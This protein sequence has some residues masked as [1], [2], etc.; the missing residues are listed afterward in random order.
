VAQTQKSGNTQSGTTQS[1]DVP[2]DDDLLERPLTARSVMASLL[3]GMDRPR[4]RGA[5]LVRW[6]RLFG[7]SEG[8]ARV[9]LSRMVA[10]DE[11]VTGDGSYELAGRL[12]LR[13]REQE[14][15]LAPR[16][17]AWD[18]AWSMATVDPVARPPAD[19]QVLRDAMRHLRC[20]EVREGVWT[21]PDNLPDEAAPAGARAAADAH[22]S[23][24]SARPDGE[25]SV[26]A[27]DWFDLTRW[28]ARGEDL[29]RRL[30]V[31]ADRLTAG[32][33]GLEADAFVVGAAAL[34]H[35]RADPLLPIELLPADWPG[36]DLRDAYRGYRAAFG[37]ATAE[38][39]ARNRS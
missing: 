30:A 13:Q 5:L 38:W 27:A 37:D 32:D 26:L 2:V 12:G 9:A 35:V 24:W 18:G 34:V 25:P 31:V 28:A 23:W 33:A 11:L 16:T 4:M 8:T 20:A 22:C 19:R 10:R 36:D 7:I 1:G 29:R 15:S 21:R 14:W 17:R 6:C 3:L 39:F